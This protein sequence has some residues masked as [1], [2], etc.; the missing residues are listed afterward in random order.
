[1]TKLDDSITI[2]PPLFISRH[3]KGQIGIHL[4][5]L[6]K[7]DN[8]LS[9]RFSQGPNVLATKLDWALNGAI[10][11]FQVMK[12]TPSMLDNELEHY[13]GNHSNNLENHNIPV[14]PSSS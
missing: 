5:G 6:V 14:G 2:I 11:Y 3:A 4:E 7:L 1:M 12:T 8:R 10:L 13:T 9:V